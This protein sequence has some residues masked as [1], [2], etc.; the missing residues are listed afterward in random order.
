MSTY[1]TLCPITR[2]C[3]TRLREQAV[4]GSRTSKRRVQQL[5][6]LNVW[7][8]HCWAWE[9][10]HVCRKNTSDTLGYKQAVV[11]HCV[12]NN[13]LFFQLCCVLSL[14][15]SVKSCENSSV[16]QLYLLSYEFHFIQN[17]VMGEVCKSFVH[18][19]DLLQCKDKILPCFIPIRSQT[20]PCRASMTVDESGNIA[21]K[22]STQ[23][24]NGCWPTTLKSF[25]FVFF[26]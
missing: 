12:W 7:R 21:G 15:L 5:K 8:S 17:D 19:N 20:L 26:I 24:L 13:V 14:F 11:L 1:S 23:G 9:C 2:G 4:T 22:F 3:G 6:K 18:R 25:C 10:L 16:V